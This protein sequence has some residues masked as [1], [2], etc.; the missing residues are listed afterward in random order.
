MAHP[1][2]GAFMG[3]Q[4][5]SLRRFLWRSQQRIQNND[6]F[7]AWLDHR[8]GDREIGRIDQWVA[9]KLLVIRKWF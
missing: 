3:N 5:L 6:L 7:T 2:V 4:E 9:A 1:V 8:L